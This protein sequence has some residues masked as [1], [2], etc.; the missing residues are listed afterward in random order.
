MLCLFHSSQT[1]TESSTGVSSTLH[2]INYMWITFKVGN[3]CIEE[4][5]G[6]CS[7]ASTLS[8]IVS[9]HT[10]VL[11]TRFLYVVN[12]QFCQTLQKTHMLWFE[13]TSAVRRWTTMVSIF[14]FFLWDRSFI[15]SLNFFQ[16]LSLADMIA[17]L[18]DP[19]FA[20][21]IIGKCTKNAF[22]SMAMIGYYQFIF[23]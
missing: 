2:S 16:F 13:S 9:K 19:H 15:F 12:R 4:Q 14:P 8:D 11:P 17:C 22:W 18:V 7:P 1:P 5:D 10:I 21:G 3:C 20:K 23:I 6:P